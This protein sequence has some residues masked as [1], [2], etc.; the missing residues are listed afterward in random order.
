L[1]GTSTI[2]A[3][4]AIIPDC[5]VFQ[6]WPS[7]IQDDMSKGKPPYGKLQ[8]YYDRTLAMLGANS[9]ARSQSLKKDDVFREVSGYAGGNTGM[10]I[11]LL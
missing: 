6:L 9:Y 5:E 8:D 3:N 2:N 11:S 10:E 1:G 4:V 7:Q